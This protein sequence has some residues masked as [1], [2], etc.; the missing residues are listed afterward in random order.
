MM[1]ATCFRA[2]PQR[3]ARTTPHPGVRQSVCMHAYLH[4][5]CVCVLKCIPHERGV[6]QKARMCGRCYPLIAVGRK[7][8]AKCP[9]IPTLKSWCESSCCYAPAFPE[10]GLS[11]RLTRALNRYQSRHL[12]SGGKCS[13]K[14]RE[15]SCTGS[16]PAGAPHYAHTRARTYTDQRIKVCCGGEGWKG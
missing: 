5:R 9:H 2:L 11:L 8:S 10:T 12:F 13:S 15:R 3:S 6:T 4:V 1:C 14:R 7:H 16:G